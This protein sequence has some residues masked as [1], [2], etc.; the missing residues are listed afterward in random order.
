MTPD[1]EGVDA[2]KEAL[3]PLD[4][5]LGTERKSLKVYEDRHLPSRWVR[6]ERR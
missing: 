5:G 4:E 6:I 1:E 3:L 2:E